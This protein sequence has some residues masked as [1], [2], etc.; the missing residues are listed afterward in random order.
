M[1]N[2]RIR[3]PYTVNIRA[4]PLIEKPCTTESEQVGFI[5]NFMIIFVNTDFCYT[6]D[7]FYVL[8]S[9]LYR[10]YNLLVKHKFKTD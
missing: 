10:N 5:V 3:P 6:D 1:Q 9:F 4:S 7:S 8:G 2:L